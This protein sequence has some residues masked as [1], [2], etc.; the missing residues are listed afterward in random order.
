MSIAAGHATEID[1]GSPP[2]IAPPPRIAES[3]RLPVLLTSLVGREADI[4]AAAALLHADV[5]LMALTGPGGV[6]KT[7]LAIAVATELQSTFADGVAFVSLA[8]VTD[9]ELVAATI[10]SAL[11]VRDGDARSDLARVIDLLRHRHVLLVLDTF[12]QVSE[13]APLVVDLLGAAPGLKVL[14]T[15]RAT[16]HVRGA[17]EFMVPPLSLPL[18]TDPIGTEDLSRYPATALFVA[19]AMDVRSDLTITPVSAAAIVEICAKLDGLPLAIELAAARSTVLSPPALLNRL[20]RRLALL[21]GGSRDLPTRQQTLR[22][23]ITWSYDLLT[24]N[25]QSIFRGL[26]VFSGG[27]TLEAAESVVRTHLHPSAPESGALPSSHPS[28]LDELFVLVGHSLVRRIEQAGGESR[29]HL[30]D[31]IREFA[32]EALNADESEASTGFRLAH[33]AWFTALAEEVGPNLHGAD[34]HQWWTRL[35]VEH[36]NLRVALTW[37]AD[38]EAWTDCLRLAGALWE[39]WWFGGH[40]REGSTWLLRSLEHASAAP[41]AL[42]AR[43]LEGAS[44]LIHGLS[45]HERAIPLLEESRRLYEEV[46]DLRGA[47]AATYMLGVVAEDLGDFDRAFELLTDAAA[48]SARAGDRRGKA[49][50]LLHLGMVAYGQADFLGRRPTVSRG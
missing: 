11:G 16:L 46:G 22:N 33:V 31:T 7:R 4:A 6:G 10:A 35:Q 3:A 27:C 43:A 14:V 19:R 9:P 17:R 34:Q 26:A 23:T 39:Y 5:R 42:R 48:S 25:Q 38:Q 20:E 49:F 44:Y 29:L 32:L 2:V 15:S 41:A 12:E 36:G 47:G 45:D 37:L 28:V 40:L 1:P 50:A 18:T 30:L 13:A 21:T 8:Q 24:P